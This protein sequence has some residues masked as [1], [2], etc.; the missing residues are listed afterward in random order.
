MK[1]IE[2]NR[3]SKAKPRNVTRKTLAEELGLH[4]RDLRPIFSLSQVATLVSRGPLIILNIGIIKLLITTEKVII[5]NVEDKFIF[6]DFINGLKLRL[7]DPENTKEPIEVLVL[8]YALQ[9]K[10]HRFA[11]QAD[12]LE[13]SVQ[14]LLKK[15]DSEHSE[16]DLEKLLLNKKALS[17]LEINIRENIEAAEEV[18]EDDDELQELCI[19]QIEN[20]VALSDIQDEEIESIID[21]F[22][23]Q[24]EVALHRVEEIKENID[25]T[26]E[27][28]S[29]KLG[30]ERNIIIRFELVATLITALFSL[31]AVVT[32]LYGMNIRNNLENDHV[33]FW[34]IVLLFILVFIT[35]VFWM[36]YKL[37]KLNIF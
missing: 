26:Q 24:V 28:V 8:D 7:K 37:K 32:G 10:A 2:L 17:K 36:W 23:E 21:S 1:I 19:T 18:I 3:H 4:V 16:K 14:R 25:D 11:D 33:A 20:G 22:I 27:I 30:T 15:L 31:M 6:G 35:F 5:A 29:L 13:K 12:Q 9:V 34:W